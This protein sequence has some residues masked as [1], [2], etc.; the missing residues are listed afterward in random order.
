GDASPFAYVWL[1]VHSGFGLGDYRSGFR[2]GKLGFDLV[3]RRGLSRYKAQVYLNFAHSILPWSRPLHESVSLLRRAFVVAQEDGDLAH[4][5]YACTCLLSDLLA[6]G[7]PLAEVQREAE[8]A[9][10]FLRE[11]K[12]GL[13]LDTVKAQFHLILALRGLTSSLSSFS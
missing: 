13:I 3:E 12:F 11:A 2:L 5:A 10:A 1:G 8:H 4:A 7:L 9:L 6:T